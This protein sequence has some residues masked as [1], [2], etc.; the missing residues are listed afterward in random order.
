MHGRNAL[1]AGYALYLRELT[2]LIREFW[3][4]WLS[5]PGDYKV[6]NEALLAETT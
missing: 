5:M 4:P 3:D 2:N 6:T 1:P